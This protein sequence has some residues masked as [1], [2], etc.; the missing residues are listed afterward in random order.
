MTDFLHEEVYTAGGKEG[1]C[2]I[3]PKEDK[4]GR[5]QPRASLANTVLRNVDENCPKR[6]D[7]TGNKQPLGWM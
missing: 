7:S 6:N 1:H 5:I 2:G 3:E 4:N